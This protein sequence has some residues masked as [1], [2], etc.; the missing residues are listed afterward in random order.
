MSLVLYAITEAGEGGGS[1]L[2]GESLRTVSEGGLTAVVSVHAGPRGTPDAA[3]DLWEYERVVERLMGARAILPMRFGTV[4]GDEQAVR[5]LI[6]ERHAALAAGLERVR[7]T[8]EVAV[9]AGWREPEPPARA[10][11]PG[12]TYMLDRL[13]LHRRARELADRLSPLAEMAREIHTR[14]LARGNLPVLGAYLVER[15]K[16]TEFTDSVRDLD[17]RHADI[18]LVCTGPWPP[19]SFAPGAQA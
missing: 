18:E 12:T 16:V 6:R 5:G 3:A 11:G 15:E 14:F 17:E 2:H 4:L 19:Y 8:V 9:R 1:G 7:G 10:D 13:A